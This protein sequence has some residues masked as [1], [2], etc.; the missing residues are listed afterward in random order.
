MNKRLALRRANLQEEDSLHE[1]IGGGTVIEGWKAWK[2]SRTAHKASS[3][4]LS[5]R[6]LP[7]DTR[8]RSCAVLCCAILCCA[9]LCRIL[10]AMSGFSL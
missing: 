9:V 6:V 1:A 5:D 3:V 7:R 8:A 10:G 4:N 2:K